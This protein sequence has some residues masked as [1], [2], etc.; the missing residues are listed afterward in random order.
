ML[1]WPGMMLE[2]PGM[3]LKVAWDDVGMVLEWPG[4]MLEYIVLQGCA[5][6]LTVPFRCVYITL[7]MCVC[8]K[9]YNKCSFCTTNINT[10][11]ERPGHTAIL[12]QTSCV[13]FNQDTV[14][15]RVISIT[16]TSGQT[17]DIIKLFA[18]SSFS[19]LSRGKHC[20]ATEEQR[21]CEVTFTLRTC[22][23]F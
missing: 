3:M 15:C 17:S 21:C 11:S 16:M 23:Q 10:Q 4:M 2:W 18:N 9:T 19:T 7:T 1:E 12:H 22:S 13:Y 8:V 14:E 20:C 5:V 6:Q